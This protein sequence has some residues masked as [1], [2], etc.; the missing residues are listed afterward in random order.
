MASIVGHR[1]SREAGRA[2]YEA[3]FKQNLI[4]I[5][6]SLRGSLRGL[7]SAGHRSELR[8]RS[9]PGRTNKSA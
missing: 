6:L 5:S 1:T 3:F 9:I 2:D 7:S 8:P 4:K